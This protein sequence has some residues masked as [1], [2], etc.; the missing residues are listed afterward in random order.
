[1]GN[2]RKS[3]FKRTYIVD[4]AFQ[5]KFVLKIVFFVVLATIITGVVTFF[6]T[7]EALERS[8]YS[9]HYQIKNVWQILLPSVVV[10]SFVT[11]TIVAVFT[12]I[13]ALVASHK[14]GGPLYRFKKS[15]KSIEEGDLTIDTKLRAR[16][17]LQDF[18]GSLNSMT[19][20][21]KEKIS[22]IDRVYNELSNDIDAV[23]KS[24][25]K[26]AINEKDKALLAALRRD[27]DALGE[28]INQFKFKE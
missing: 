9:I 7:N 5:L 25:A 26:S 8:F 4:Y 18:V 19:L 11:T 10:I 20:S 1:M 22:D 16:D 3:F 12:T 28:S 27:V 24:F 6:I 21:V 2:N 17:D 15:L 23:N 13:V 14:V